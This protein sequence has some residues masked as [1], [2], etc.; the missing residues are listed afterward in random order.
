MTK[1]D[2]KGLKINVESLNKAVSEI[3]ATNGPLPDLYLQ[4]SYHDRTRLTQFIRSQILQ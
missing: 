4:I 1:L 2:L 3:P